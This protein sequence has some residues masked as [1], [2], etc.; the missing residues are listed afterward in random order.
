MGDICKNLFTF[1]FHFQLDQFFN[2]SFD[3]NKSYIY[4][5][6]LLIMWL[7]KKVLIGNLNEK[8]NLYVKKI[9]LND[10][11]TK[12]NTHEMHFNEY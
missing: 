4:M 1:N 2:F 6:L 10:D 7:I 8:Y 9:V 12:L 11:L 3:N 5:I